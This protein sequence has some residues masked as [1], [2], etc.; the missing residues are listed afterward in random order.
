[1]VLQVVRDNDPMVVRIPS[2]DRTHMLKSPR[3]H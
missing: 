3:L 2:A 1:V